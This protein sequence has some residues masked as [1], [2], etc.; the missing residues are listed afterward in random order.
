MNCRKCSQK[1]PYMVEIDGKTKYLYKRVYCLS[2]SPFGGNNRKSLENY[3]DTEKTC[4]MCHLL[5]PTSEFYW[6]EKEQRH[7]RYCK[8]CSTAYDKNKVKQFKQLCLDYLGGKCT[9]C[10]YNKC[11]AALDFHHLDPTKKEFPI[12]RKKQLT[13]TQ[14]I[15]DELDKC[16]ILCANC[17]REHHN[18]E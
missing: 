16:T 1:I 3:T 12:P 11:N 4:S 17:H 6:A 5:K 8:Q 7:Y 9:K 14:P 13:L 18:L 2:C 15:K 10:G